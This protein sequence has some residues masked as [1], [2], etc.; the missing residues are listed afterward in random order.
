M[1]EVLESIFEFLTIIIV[2]DTGI[3]IAA[4]AAIPAFITAAI[5]VFF[6]GL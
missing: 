1:L 6:Y 3:V 5:Y 4:L 2:S